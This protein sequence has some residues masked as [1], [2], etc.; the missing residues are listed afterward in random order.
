MWLP[1]LAGTNAKQ[2]TG[3]GLISLK[4]LKKSL[5]GWVIQAKYGII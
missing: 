5:F 2:Q 1:L 3:L 4:K